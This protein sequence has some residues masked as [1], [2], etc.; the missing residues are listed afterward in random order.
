MAYNQ[1][2][3]LKQNIDAA[4]IALTW[5][6]GKQLSPVD[7][8]ALQLYSGF[9]GIKTILYP[10]APKSEWA[11]MGARQEDMRMHQPMREFHE[12]LRQQLPKAAYHE[13]IS[14]LKTDTLTAFY[15][16][17][18]IPRAVYTALAEEGIQPRRLY[19]PSAG[20][21]IFITEAVNQFPS[22]EKVTA[23]EKDL[24]TGRVLEAVNSTLGVA[25][26]THIKGFEETPVTDNETYDLI[27]SNI[28]FGNIAV[29]DEAYFDKGITGKISN[30]FFAKG[31]DKIADGGL[32]A[33]ITAD[34]FINNPSNE[35]ARQYLFER[36]DL[37]SLAVLPD[38]LMKETG[39]TESPCHLV[40]VQKN[41]RKTS[42]SPAEE[43][44]LAIATLRNDRGEYYQSQYIIN[45]PDIRLGDDIKEG[46]D[47]YGTP[48]LA[49][50]QKGE[51]A[52]IGES[53]KL[54]LHRDFS[55]RLDKARFQAAPLEAPK[56]AAE[57]KKEFTFLP[58]PE[59]AASVP[60]TVQIGLFDIAPVENVNRA[61]A[62]LAEAD[63]TVILR[64]SA[65]VISTISTSAFPTH[66]TIALLTAKDRHSSRYMY[67]L[68]S[69]VSEISFPATW[70]NGNIL[71]RELQYLSGKL[72][73]FDYQYNYKGDDSYRTT[74]DLE[75]DA[76]KLFG[77]LM[78]FHRPGTLLID[79]GKVGLVTAIDREARS[80]T[81]Q[82]FP[83]GLK[84]KRLYESYIPLRDKY[85]ELVSLEAEGIAFD[86][87]RGQLN[88]AYDNFV[89]IYGPLNSLSNKKLL[90]QDEAFGFKIAS[91]VERREGEEYVK[92][93]IMYRAL[94]TGPEKLVTT[95]PSDA[96]SVCLNDKGRVD[97][98][99]IAATCGQS[100]DDCIEA[101]INL[102]FL[103]PKNQRWETTEEYLSGNVVEKLAAAEA[104]AA[105]SPDNFLFQRSL[106]AIKQVQPNLIAFEMLDF[107]LGERWIPT[108][109]YS[110]FVSEV[111]DTPTT[112]TYLPSLDIFRVEPSEQNKKVTA[113]Y[114][115]KP[116][117]GV[118]MYGNTIMQHAL[119]NTAP[120]FTYEVKSG[121]TSTRI[122]DN[123]AT[124][125]AHQK[126]EQIRQQFTD[127][128]NRLPETDK[129][130]LETRYNE[131]YNC[132]V[133]R[134]YNGGHLKFPG[135]DLERLGI[136][137]LFS[138]Q[139]DATWRITQ[140]RGGLIDHGVGLG[141]TLTAIV[142]SHEMK[143]LKLVNKPAIIALKANVS[144][145]Y[146]TYRKAYPEARVL[147]PGKED[148]T[149]KQR[150][151]IYH[152]IM[153]NDWDCIILTHE[154]FS[155]IRQSPEIQK[156]II[157][158]ELDDME[159]DLHILST[160]GMTVSKK[161]MKGLESQKETLKGK[162]NQAIKDIDSKKDREITF[163]QLGIDHLT[164]DESHLFKNLQFTTR[165]TRVRGLGNMIG[166]QRALN[167]L[168]AI[169]TLQEKF[170]SDYCATFLSGTPI[171]NSLSEMYLLFKYLRPG[172]LE[173]RQMSNFDA[174]A[175]VHAC[176]STEFQFSITNEIISVE[177]FSEFIKVPELALMYSEMTDY[178]T[179]DHIKL[180]KPSLEEELVC[181]KPSPQQEAFMEKL[182]DFARSGKDPVTGQQLSAK[183]DE[184]RML[185]AFNYAKKMSND[186]R[187]ISADYADHPHNK[188]SE[189]ARNIADWY[190]KSDH[191]K[192]TQLF[193]CDIG[194]P[195][196][197]VF[198]L[199]DAL[200]TKLI[201]DFHIPAAEISFIHDWPD[202]KKPEL[203]EKFNKGVVRI[204]GGSTPKIGTG[205]NVQ[206]RVV[207]MH[208]IDIP[209]VP[210]VLEQRGGRG[211]RQG[212]TIAR[213]HFGNKVKFYF[214][215]TER[216]L[217]VFNFNLCKNKLFFINQVKNAD[218][219]VRR[220]DEGTMDENG[221]NLNQYIALLSGN[222][223]LLEKARLESKIGALETAKGAFMREIN[224]ARF[225]LAHAQKELTATRELIDKYGA[226]SKQYKSV[227][228]YDKEQV[229]LNP[230]QLSSLQ[231]VDPQAIGQYL[232]DMQKNTLPDPSQQARL[233][234]G[235]YGFECYL[236]STSYFTMTSKERII[237]NS[238]YLYSPETG[239]K[240]NYNDGLVNIDNP[241]A[242][243]RYFLHAIDRVDNLLSH[244]K[245]IQA[246]L[247]KDIPQLQELT[248]KT[249][250]GEAG[251]RILKDELQKLEREI[252]LQIQKEQ[253]KQEE[254][255]GGPTVVTVAEDIK[256]LAG[257]TE[258]LKRPLQPP[259]IM[260][261]TSDTERQDYR[262]AL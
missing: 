218:I 64:Q 8:A 18:V 186:M 52:E 62:Y 256:V 92:A 220:I 198:N 250:Q 93:D 128:L 21:G 255:K 181:L 101:L 109:Y 53:L 246:K 73:Q 166:S 81:F 28:P 74:F 225:E 39:D 192:G 61:I 35:Q 229:K 122:N 118:T 42:L 5:K 205:C 236:K 208:S 26:T 25:T 175:A 23:V 51:M 16:P 249:F 6:P 97:M 30:Y 40:I 217:D 95:D 111:F 114:A 203:F 245:D 36:A 165:H 248:S 224:N 41:I 108:R 235:L 226:D 163:E 201:E 9:G 134:H 88:Y 206:A 260:P 87:L 129:R 119:E 106:I 184:W 227:L 90:L 50:W 100:K 84:D 154:Q 143:R 222:T 171:S 60:S 174:W 20:A 141:K 130:E 144:E 77:R 98:D 234:G 15:T 168:F 200:K 54:L 127:W 188:V 261:G 182:K 157:Q 161:M 253:S 115:I 193:F 67:K 262:K 238:F 214:Y 242:A 121:G 89:K 33:F 4:R 56:E 152:E 172:E 80:A 151:R 110:K 244:Q 43:E 63:G 247:E 216:S 232:I 24:L 103:N 241:K 254:G 57:R 146:S 117:S 135:L 138:S 125:L 164:V 1:F 22:L 38:N 68:V 132:I 78:P 27:A 107:N 75:N 202:K 213:D 17:D 156:K 177:R 209:L 167:M 240:Y 91:S 31:L 204:L 19:E 10:D 29:F 47:Q 2:R 231:S 139:K 190:H 58:V 159:H 102:V 86:A 72:Q 65:K 76:A 194:T 158:Q 94:T 71:S 150:Q 32:L 212:N 124:Q 11:K 83:D 112:V 176:K 223:T 219:Q 195:K 239:L 252:S 123:E 221:M 228:K 12:F 45:H 49:V 258:V 147:A 120:F 7:I 37:V 233:I 178:K 211:A 59:V 69:N 251:L 131:T 148:F 116:Q 46:Y 196:P 189:C 145:V 199:Y 160:Q 179:A 126:I 215:A 183:E 3:K 185:Y 153:N 243:A 105:A 142:S 136:K 104:Q 66:E 259:R 14:S 70:M 191:V 169:R 162:L 44:L 173:R 207:A 170:Q 257:S 82:S 13:I 155:K 237:E 180:Q 210:S 55:E 230:L 149:P 197:G 48:S 85:L 137:G 99:F 140:N 133:L 113:E 187:L 34:R 79:G 96:L